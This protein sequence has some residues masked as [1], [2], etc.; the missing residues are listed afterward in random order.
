MWSGSSF[1]RLRPP[2]VPAEKL[3]VP[4]Y[5][6]DHIIFWRVYEND[7]YYLNGI[8]FVFFS[9]FRMLCFAQLVLSS[10]WYEQFNHN[11]HMYTSVV[12]ITAYK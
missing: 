11:I 6:R 7:A 9:Y 2:I 10:I 4:V 3:P 1:L 5:T 8:Y 12:A